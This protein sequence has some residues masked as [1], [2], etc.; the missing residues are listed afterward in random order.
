MIAAIILAAGESSRMGTPKALLPFKDSTFLESILL[1]V[2]KAKYNNIIIVLGQHYG[3]IC[4][5]IP[6]KQD[7][8]VIRNPNPEKGQLSSLQLALKNVKDEA[9]GVL[10]VLV[11]HPLVSQ[12][13]YQIIYE[14]ACAQP[15]AIIIPVYK[16]RKGHPVYFA[17]KFF[18]ALIQ[19]PLN[20][21]A[22]YVVHNNKSSVVEI[23]VEDE[24]IIMDIDT[25]EQYNKIS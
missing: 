11:D 6:I 9:Q 4:R 5:S 3:R 10:I 16:N 24:G 25:R 20:Q 13:T 14:H 12:V 18:N 7:H 17:R 2:R 1:K 23:P 15:D 8:D 21:G 22:R 19:A